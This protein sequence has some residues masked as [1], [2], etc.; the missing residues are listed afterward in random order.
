[1]IFQKIGYGRGTRFFL[2]GF[3]W[4]FFF[5]RV[6]GDGPYEVEGGSIFLIV[7]FGGKW[8]TI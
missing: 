2:I 1:M 8:E 3:F 5:A 6:R 4:V 7:V